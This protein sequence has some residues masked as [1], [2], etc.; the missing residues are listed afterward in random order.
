MAND[1]TRAVEWDGRIAGTLSCLHDLKILSIQEE[2]LVRE[3]TVSQ[4]LEKL[5]NMRNGAA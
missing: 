1:E 3:Y 4:M 5:E 2:M